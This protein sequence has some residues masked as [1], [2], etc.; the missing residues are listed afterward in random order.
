MSEPA[1]GGGEGRQ[2]ASFV[3]TGGIA[4][5]ANV[6]TRWLLSLAMV[7]ELAV[8]LAYLVG[9]TTAFVL[10]RRYVFASTGS[11]IGEY[12]R[13]ALVNVFSF[14][15]VLGVSVGLARVVFPRIG[16]TWHAEDIAHL[17]GVASPILL[18]FYAHKYFSFG[19]RAQ[20]A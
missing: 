12:G 9:L 4:A 8:T 19:K 5:L 1:T 20:R 11:W 13:F 7:Y 6:A 14:L 16:F 2:L 17:I 3:V 18:S 15:M 10:A